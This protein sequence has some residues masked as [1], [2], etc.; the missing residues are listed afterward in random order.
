MA[1]STEWQS[2]RADGMLVGQEQEMQNLDYAT[3]VVE[4][5]SL[6]D[7]ETMDTKAVE[8]ALA[9]ARQTVHELSFSTSTRDGAGPPVELPEVKVLH[10]RLHDLEREIVAVLA[11]RKTI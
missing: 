1:A 7:P 8:A 2:I 9:D 5:L 11:Q 10:Q 6:L 4:G 3:K